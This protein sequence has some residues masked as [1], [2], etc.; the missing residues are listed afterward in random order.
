MKGLWC[1]FTLYDDP[2]GWFRVQYSYDADFLAEIKKVPLHRRRR[3]DPPEDIYWMIDPIYKDQLIE[4]AKSNFKRVYL[5][6]PTGFQPIQ[7]DQQSLG[8]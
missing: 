4:K 7:I 6:T 1:H 3:S 2:N 5:I 8:A